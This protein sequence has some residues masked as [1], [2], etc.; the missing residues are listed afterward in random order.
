MFPNN[1]PLNNG[2]NQFNINNMNNNFN[3]QI[4]ANNQIIGNNNMLN[5]MDNN[6]NFNFFQNLNMNNQY[7]NFNQNCC[8]NNMNNIQ[9]NNNFNNIRNNNFNIHMNNNQNGFID[10][11]NMIPNFNQNFILNQFNNIN[12]NN[13]NYQGNQM[14]QNNNNINPIIYNNNIN[15]DIERDNYKKYEINYYRDLICEENKIKASNNLISNK[16]GIKTIYHQIK[17]SLCEI[18]KNATG[19]FCHIPFQDK[20]LPVLITCKNIIGD[21][22][23]KENKEINVSLDDN[24]TQKKIKL[25]ENKL[26][27]TNDKYN[28]TFIEIKPD[29]NIDEK[30]FLELDENLFTNNSEFIIENKSLYVLHYSKK[31][32]ISIS[33]GILDKKVGAYLVLSCEIDSIGSPIFNME[34]NKVIGLITSIYHYG[35]PPYLGMFL[36][37][38][39]NDFNK[40]DN[41][42]IIT[43]DIDNFYINK[44]V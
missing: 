15:S 39:L 24:K 40:I 23:L 12:L 3:N 21:Y 36:K 33:Y 37:Y 44:D 9:T 26:I 6:N 38:A 22:F 28:I 27:Y 25:N 19:F 42:I 43:L 14:N 35:D 29:D 13:I 17:N 30:N 16:K 41:Q 18:W 5:L 10:Y 2:M 34:N 4:L 11:N 8:P 31:N 20:K 32:S 1:N 7:N